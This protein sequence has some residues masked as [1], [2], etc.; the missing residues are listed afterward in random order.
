MTYNN[1]LQTNNINL[2]SVL[3]TV[4][5]L[6]S[7]DSLEIQKWTFVLEDDATVDKYIEVPKYINIEYELSSVISFSNTITK[8]K[9]GETYKTMLSV[10]DGCQLTMVAL[11]IV[12]ANGLINEGAI[13][14]E[15][16][17]GK[18]EYEIILDP[19]TLNLQYENLEII[20]FI[21]RAEWNFEDFE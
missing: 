5:N 7:K 4:N 18:S 2:Q 12:Y 16:A 10:R 14:F 3:N 11:D 20:A 6:P 17:Y 19:Y 13:L 21:I 8:I 1:D 9:V 15:D